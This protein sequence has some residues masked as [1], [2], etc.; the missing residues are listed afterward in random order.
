[1]WFAKFIINQCE[2]LNNPIAK[3]IESLILYYLTYLCLILHITND[4][5]QQRLRDW[6]IHTN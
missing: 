4:N 3:K 2:A 5:K 1:M 6:L